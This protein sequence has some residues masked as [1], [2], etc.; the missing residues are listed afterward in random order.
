MPRCEVNPAVA[1]R[2]GAVELFACQNEKTYRATLFGKQNIEHYFIYFL[3]GNPGES[4][5]ERFIFEVSGTR[6]SAMSLRVPQT[7]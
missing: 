4:G 3:S 2:C 1:S 5:E 6:E 7:I